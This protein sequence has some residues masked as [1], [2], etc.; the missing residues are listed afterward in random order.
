MKKKKLFMLALMAAV[1]STATITMA[2]CDKKEDPIEV[3]EKTLDDILVSGL[4]TNYVAGDT[5]SKDGLKVTAKYS[6]GSE[7]DITSLVTFDYSKL[8]LTTAGSYEVKFT[9]EGKS[10]SVTIVVAPQ[11]IVY[12]DLE[13]AVEGIIAADDKVNGGTLEV[14][15]GDS[16]DYDYK[17][18]YTYG[19]GYVI[20]KNTT[21]DVKNYDNNTTSDVYEDVYL[22]NNDGS[23]FGVYVEKKKN[24][25]DT[26]TES[27]SLLRNGSEEYV[28]RYSDGIGGIDSRACYKTGFTNVLSGSAQNSVYGAANFVNFLYEEY[29][30]QEH[31]GAYA[32]KGTCPHLD[33]AEGFKFG[34]NYIYNSGDSASNGT[35]YFRRATIEFTTDAATG[36]VDKAYVKIEKFSTEDLFGV[37]YISNLAEAPESSKI[38]LTKTANGTYIYTFTEEAETSNVNEYTITQS[39]GAKADV[40]GNK[41]SIDKVMISSFEVVDAIR[42][43]ELA[44]SID[45]DLN[46]GTYDEDMGKSRFRYA[47][48]IR[49]ILP[50]TANPDLDKID[51]IV[52]GVGANGHALTG[53]TLSDSDY[54]YANLSEKTLIF[55]YPGTYTVTFKSQNVQKT[56][57][58]NVSAEAP[59]Y[60]AT[61]ICEEDSD[62]FVSS[63]EI[64]IFQSNTL[65]IN[66]VN[67]NSKGAIEDYRFDNNYTLTIVDAN[68]NIVENPTCTLIKNADKIN[69]YECYKFNA[70]DAGTYYIKMTGAT[71][72]TGEAASTTLKIIVN[73]NP[74]VAE[75]LNG[76]YT[77]DVN[78]TKY[79]VVFTPDAADSLVGSAVI[80]N[81]TDETQTETI[82]YNYTDGKISTNHTAGSEFN[83]GFALTSKYVLC[84]KLNNSSNL[85]TCYR[86]GESPEDLG[87]IAKLISGAYKFTIS[88][89]QDKYEL[90]FIPS[91]KGS[92]SGKL[93][94]TNTDSRNDTSTSE[95]NYSY[96]AST[97]L[98]N[99]DGNKSFD[100]IIKVE[101]GELI[102]TK[103]GG[104]TLE[105]VELDLTSICSGD[106]TLTVDNTGNGEY[107]F[108]IKFSDGKVYINNTN[109]NLSAYYTYAYDENTEQLKL[110]LESGSSKVGIQNNLYI[111]NGVL[112]FKGYAFV[113]SVMGNVTIPCKKAGS[114]TEKVTILEKYYGTWKSANETLIISEDGATID[115]HELEVLSCDDTAIEIKVDEYITIVLTYS[116][117]ALIDEE[118]QVEYGYFDVTAINPFVGKWVDENG[119]YY[120]LSADKLIYVSD[121]NIISYT[122]WSVNDDT[123][124]LSGN[125]VFPESLTLSADG[126]NLTNA[127][128]ITFDKYI[129]AVPEELQGQWVDKYDTTAIITETTMTYNDDTYTVK[130]V[131]SSKLVFEFDYYGEP[132]TIEF[133]I[134]ADGT[135]TCSDFFGSTVILTKTGSSSDLE[136]DSTFINSW[137]NEEDEITLIITESSVMYN[138]ETCENVR[139][140]L[141]ERTYKLYFTNAEN[142]Y[143][144]TVSDG[145][146]T[147]T[148]SGIKI[149]FTIK[150][151]S[152]S[153][154]SDNSNETTIASNF[155][156]TWNGTIDGAAVTIEI[157]ESSVKYNNESVTYEFDDNYT[158]VLM[159]E[160]G[161]TIYYCE[162]ARGKLYVFLGED[163]HTEGISI[164]FTFAK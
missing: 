102:Y 96:D 97:K 109:K 101:N 52:D 132:S 84:A 81:T 146:L 18:E 128:G 64:E 160:V 46:D 50:D 43:H 34:F 15:Y 111:T 71:P 75:I 90:N 36:A 79:S 47:Y 1:A 27:A 141:D 129:L 65:Y 60:V 105:K 95:Y 103:F 118:N 70:T 86:P 40:S 104:I 161:E 153:E 164:T 19:D 143:V 26:F 38:N 134:N 115:G 12:E 94:I 58:F 120:E 7:V 126:K 56:V 117:S 29:A 28:T 76:S 89:T 144:C 13:A 107:K 130:E 116:S 80:T 91:E 9:Y 106:Y 163:N 140:E 51:V 39:I 33:N 139:C 16:G 63:N 152:G 10:K 44:D 55:N 136:I 92:L 32:E 133:V 156:G 121:G 114:E 99:V 45:I 127:D 131:T 57:I 154:D 37:T 113:N 155:I 147:A 125:G 135:L 159:F 11:V 2:S 24:S 77:V 6:D 4:K 5:F 78:G 3:P 49:S 124:T 25:D 112:C 137:Y 85:F 48:V 157:T 100:K 83:I 74:S 54:A 17:C 62:K 93:I 142:D 35:F 123:I 20:A 110:T 61:R 69:G 31:G 88:K 73:A 149:V 82:S 138:N 8:D 59:H 21:Y 53:N 122:N 162:V 30:F 87:N 119:N 68:G 22:S 72:K 41:Y 148:T 158:P 42:G 150:D 67:T 145:K 66:G 23:V 151:T 108:E 98:I 14:K